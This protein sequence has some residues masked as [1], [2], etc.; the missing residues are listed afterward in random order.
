MSGSSPAQ[1]R[2]IAATLLE[3]AKTATTRA[4]ITELARRARITRP[5]LYRNHP[6]LVAEFLADAA[7]H[8]QTAPRPRLAQ[9]L[10]ER[11]AK[12]RQDNEDLRLHVEHYE[13]HIRRLTVDNNRLREQV[14][15][16]SAIPRLDDRRQLRTQR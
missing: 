10:L 15:Q 12:L 1:L 11:I 3:E 14:E 16:L 8:R 13:E 7:Q 5:T 9:D 2:A 4:T 6:Q